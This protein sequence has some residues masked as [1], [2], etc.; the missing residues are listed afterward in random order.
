MSSFG[1]GGGDENS[2][3]QT[4]GKNRKYLEEEGEEE[5]KSQGKPSPLKQKRRTRSDSE[6]RDYI[7]GCGK[8]YLSYPAL[9]THLK[10][11]HEGKTPAG[12][13]MPQMS[14]KHTRGRPKTKVKIFLF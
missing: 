2:Y 14:N 6:H 5:R 3:P 13:S 10:Q 4:K 7:C 11:K 12:T 8:S 1:S 9:Y